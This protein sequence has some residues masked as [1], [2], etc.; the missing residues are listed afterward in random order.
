MRVKP[1]PGAWLRRQLLPRLT[2]L[3]GLFAAYSQVSSTLH[4]VIVQHVRCADHGE[5][6]H[7]GEGHPAH[8]AEHATHTSPS[9]AAA[10]ADTHGHEHCHL[11]VDPRT[12]APIP[13]PKVVLSAPGESMGPG[14]M[15]PADAGRQIALYE[16]APKTSPPAARS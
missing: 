3:L 7:V 4:W 12:F 6:V 11:L 2:L 15:R 5:W 16:L 14:L 13:A 8:E 1:T 10:D 9:V